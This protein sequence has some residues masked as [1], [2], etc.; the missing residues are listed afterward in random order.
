MLEEERKTG[1]ERKK[2]EDRNDENKIE[3]RKQR[4]QKE[5]KRK[6]KKIQE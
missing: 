1:W 6:T 4:R 5:R 3:N 2:I